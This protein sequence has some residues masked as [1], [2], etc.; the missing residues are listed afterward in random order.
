MAHM[1]Y[2]INAPKEVTQPIVRESL[3]RSNIKYFIIFLIVFH[4][5]FALYILSLLTDSSIISGVSIAMYEDYGLFLSAQ[6]IRFYIFLMFLLYLLFFLIFMLISILIDSIANKK[7][8]YLKFDIDLKNGTVKVGNK[9]SSKKISW[10]R[11]F[12]YNED[13][14]VLKLKSDIH[15]ARTIIIFKNEGITEE[16]Y[17]DL[18]KKI[19]KA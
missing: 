15:K 2:Q 11:S 4:I 3:K 1:I 17:N 9:K 12:L 19:A 6:Q 5:L 13:T 8:P 14:I 16:E 7:Y 18:L 10:N